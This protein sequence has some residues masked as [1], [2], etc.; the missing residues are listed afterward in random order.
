MIN[1]DS[2]LIKNRDV[3]LPLTCLNG[4]GAQRA[5]LFA[6]KNINSILDLLFFI[7]IRYE[8]RTQIFPINRCKENVPTFVKGNVVFGKEERFYPSRKRLFKIVIQDGEGTLEL[9]W[10]HYRKQQLNRF[11]TP[12]QELLAYGAIKINRNQMQIIHPEVFILKD[13][14]I[15]DTLGFYPVYSSIKG[16]AP[17]MVRKTVRNALKDYLGYLTDPIPDKI[18]KGLSLPG[19][20]SAVRY[21]HVPPEQSSIERLNQSN[22]PFHRRLLFDRFFLIMLTIVYRAK[23]REGKRGK[24]YSISSRLME[25]IKDF[26]PFILTSHQIKAVQDIL[27]DVASGKPMNRILMGDVG[28]G[29][30]VIAAIAAFITAQNKMQA[31]IM[32][33]TQFLARQHMEYFSGLSKK[34]GL[35]PILLA[36]R[37]KTAE[38]RDIYDKIKKGVYNL[39][40][41]TQSLIQEN[42]V[43]DK[44]GLVVIDEQHKFGV[45]ERA[46][47]EHKGENPHLLV[48]TATPI[49]RTLAI[50][51]Y[52][53]MEISTIKEY[54]EKHIPVAT[55][56]VRQKQKRRV[57]EIVKQKISSGQQ[58]FVVCPVIEGSEDLD[59]KNAIEVTEKLRKIS[60]FRI[61]LVHGRMPPDE[62][63]KIMD[64]F[65]NG[66]ID[67][68]VG[69]T[70]LEVGIHVPK[71]TVMI[72]EQPDRFGLA[73]L[74]Q[75][76]GRVGRGHENGICLLMVSD[77]LS[78][79]TM[80]RLKILVKTGDGFKIAEKDFELRGQGEIT[81]IRQSGLGELDLNEIAREP[82]L[83]SDA[84]R[85]A[86]NL[87]NSDSELLRPE[88]HNLRK[89]VESVLKRPTDL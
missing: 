71:A 49:P 14:G 16:V 54:P 43:F 72:I 11:V 30:T 83:L 60:P 22:T 59:L 76:R 41:G 66:S 18:T 85:E 3:T 10:F 15:E 9:I 45:R 31:A 47:M 89:L 32:A 25:S 88:H 81:G 69:T 58:G 75:L 68:L 46:L 38:H 79:R 52:G 8:D 70:V 33:P 19:L 63:V 4:I 6:Q 21:V 29:K 48:M 82:G 57:Y 39:I 64:D 84:K 77:N 42:L 65:R 67:I 28:C 44:L 13:N 61:G 37:L 62:R 50:T 12:N 56:I 40:I 24:V 5:R 53:D 17:N 74:H 2:H 35:S 1:R 34:T 26:F 51:V 73:Q 23:L 20:S 55:Y 86:Q 36:G 78:E 87:I 80:S 7:P 27:R